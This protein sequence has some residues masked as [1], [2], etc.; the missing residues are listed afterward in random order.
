MRRLFDTDS[1]LEYNAR[2]ERADALKLD[3]DQTRRAR[4][5]RG[6]GLSNW[7]PE[8]SGD[9]QVRRSP[10]TMDRMLASVRDQRLR[11]TLRQCQ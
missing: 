5:D 11:C 3:K 9:V 8:A 2:S 7:H 1:H 10:A 4:T 6:S